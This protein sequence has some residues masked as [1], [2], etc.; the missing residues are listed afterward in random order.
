MKMKTVTLAAF[1]ML[2]LLPIGF[3]PAA[4]DTAPAAE[5][6]FYLHD[7]D[8]VVMYGDSITDQK[9]YTV[10]TETFV[11]TRF[12]NLKIDWTA[13]GWN[14][15]GTWGGEG[16][17]IDTR[18]KRD[19]IPYRPTV[20][21][22]MLGMNDGAM[23]AFDQNRFNG[24][25]H[26][27][28]HI[29][30]TVSAGSPGVRFTLIESSPYDDITRSPNFPGGYNDVLVRYGQFVASLQSGTA[31]V[32]NFNSAVNDMLTRANNAD[33][34]LAR[35]IIPDRVHPGPA[36]HLVLAEALL[37][38]WNAPSVVTSVTIDAASK[39]VASAEFASVTNLSV[40]TA[41]SWDQLDRRLPMPYDQTDK[42]TA[43]VLTSSDFIQSLDQEPLA[44]TGLNPGNYNLSI[45]GID[46]G[47][48]SSLQL[49]EG[50]N[51]GTF[52]TPMFVQA[53][54]VQQLV[55]EHQK[56]HAEI[57]HGVQ[58]PYWDSSDPAIKKAD[59][60]LVQLLLNAEQK[61]VDQERAAAVPSV[62][63][64]TLSLAGL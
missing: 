29:L 60:R 53:Q 63:H 6:A 15:E 14:G 32:A 24:Y 47:K 13:A 8:R 34:T 45:D 30:D 23:S 42:L 38:V 26:G 58:A 18:L 64:F 27:Y 5:T 2:L 49:A 51:L 7:G 39:A 40:G 31:I 61:L 59:D 22:I 48:F 12:P 52:P 17:P 62:H 37:K 56:W 3:S 54:K 33:P 9:L 57:Y 41:I 46:L 16:G 28:R 36:G 21:T 19:I 43:F 55:S 4:A 25:T 35:T 44:V 11:T 10:D 20:F 50:V 1:G